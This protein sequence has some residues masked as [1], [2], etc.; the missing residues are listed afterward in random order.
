[1]D[2]GYIH[3]EIDKQLVKEKIKIKPMDKSFEVFN[4]DGTKNEEI[5]RFVLLKV[6]INRHKEQIN[7]AVMDLNSIDIFLGYDWLIKH[8]PEV[9]YNMGTIQFTR[10]LR[11]CRTQHQDISFRNRRIQPI[12]NQNKG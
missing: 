11:N 3:T 9:N 6:E 2:S 10:G 4:T 1:M 7:V 12:D 5:T 8:N